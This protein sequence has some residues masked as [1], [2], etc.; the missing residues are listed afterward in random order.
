MPEMKSPDG[1][2]TLNPPTEEGA[3]V[4]RALGWTGGSTR[5]QSSASSAESTEERPRRGP[6]RPR[7]NPEG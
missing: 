4:L 5:S 1:S 6:G 2:E 7:K 3:R